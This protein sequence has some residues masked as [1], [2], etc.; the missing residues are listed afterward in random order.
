MGRCRKPSLVARGGLLAYLVSRIWYLVPRER[1]TANQELP[2]ANYRLRPPEPLPLKTQHPERNTPPTC[3][4]P[5]KHR[6][7]HTRRP[8]AFAANDKTASVPPILR[9]IP[10]SNATKARQRSSNRERCFPASHFFCVGLFCSQSSWVSP[11]FL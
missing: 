7:T 8:I 11:H 9:D 4:Q 5:Y 3:L 10:D 6:H 2:T 1:G